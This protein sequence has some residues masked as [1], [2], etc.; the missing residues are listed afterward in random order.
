MPCWNFQ[1]LAI[2]MGFVVSIGNG[3]AADPPSV[4]PRVEA[5]IIHPKCDGLRD[6]P[7]VFSPDGTVFAT[8]SEK[9]VF[10]WNTRTG[11]L[12]S[13]LNASASGV[14]LDAV[15]LTPDSKSVCLAYWG[16]KSKEKGVVWGAKIECYDL[17]TLKA[18]KLVVP[19]DATGAIARIAVSA[20]GRY[21][22]YQTKRRVSVHDL[23]TDKI[24]TRL[25]CEFEVEAIRFD[26]TSKRLIIAG[27]IR[28]LES[29]LV[30]LDIQEAETRKIEVL[31]S[32]IRT[33]AVHPKTN[34]VLSAG[35]HI[36]DGKL[37]IWDPVAAKRTGTL[38]TKV[39]NGTQRDLTISH[40]G[41]FLAVC[42]RRNELFLHHIDGQQEQVATIPTKLFY[43]TPRFT[44][45]PAGDLLVL[46]GYDAVKQQHVIQYWSLISRRIGGGRTVAELDQLDMEREIVLNE[47]VDEEYFR[48]FGQARYESW[49]TDAAAG[50]KYGQF[51]V[52][53]ALLRGT[54]GV[55]SE[56][57]GMEL[58]EKSAAQSNPMALIYLASLERKDPKKAFER[59]TR[60]AETK[61]PLAL[62][63]LAGCYRDGV[64]VE[65]DVAKAFKLS[66]AAAGGE[67]GSAAAMISVGLGYQA[68]VDSKPAPELAARSFKL[69]ADRGHPDGYY[70]LGMCYLNGV[71]VAHDAKKSVELLATGARMGSLQA[72][73]SYA[74]CLER[75][76][77]CSKDLDAALGLYRELA[78][79]N[80][81]EA[82]K[83]VKEIEAI[84]Q[85]QRGEEL[86][87]LL[88]RYQ[89]LPGYSVAPIGD[90]G[91]LRER[92][93]YDAQRSAW[94]AQRNYMNDVGGRLGAYGI[95]PLP[96][97]PPPVPPI[98]YR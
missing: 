89:P 71:G 38:D 36:T 94:E 98:G 26:N 31:R 90:S 46:F 24:A 45:S 32:E 15:A 88:L 84:Q 69:A 93:I 66:L 78:R 87:R 68:G 22:A 1:V 47:P 80:H 23:T 57:K 96:L 28:H 58:L 30:I 18:Q 44:F 21:I 67:H 5:Q 76:E 39:F 17:V 7:P 85:A 29:Q 11:K 16:N 60:A 10:L 74:F 2:A 48:V 25:D 77:G 9:I 62:E 51:L 20:D 73:L 82:V 52:G 53:C 27:V 65:R 13:T 33:V 83:K 40:D 43:N 6:A 4:A 19:S 14:I 35:G 79:H 95:R 86:D 72:K 91:R 63:Y 3:I 70:H 37:G 49:K 61:H 34:A 59:Y 97:P 55:T 50:C 56:A 64:G 92:A 81:P 41:R 54:G 8:F 12:R 42:G 75:G